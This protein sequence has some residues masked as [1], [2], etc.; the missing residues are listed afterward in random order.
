MFLNIFSNSI[1]IRLSKTFRKWTGFPT[2]PEH[3][4]ISSRALPMPSSLLS[5]LVSAIAIAIITALA[6]GCSP[7]PNPQPDNQKT[8]SSSSSLGGNQQNSSTTSSKQQLT[9]PASI[10][11]LVEPIAMAFT[12]DK[13]ILITERGGNIRVVKNGRLRS[14][15]YADIIV[16]KLTGYSETGLLGIAID[17]NFK[18]KPYVYVYRTYSKN[19]KLFN[20]VIRLTDV[21]GSGREP[22]IILDNIPGGRI[23]NGGIIAF[24]PD[25]NLYISTGE[26][27]N[28]QLAQDLNSLGGKVLRIKPDGTIPA[29]NPFQNSPVFS[30]GHRNIFGMAF[31]P[32]TGALFIT[33]NG[34]DSDDEINEIVPGGNYGWPL[35]LGTSKNSRFINP[36]KT[37]PTVIA[38]TQ[39]IFYTGSILR[40]Y[41]NWFLFGAY[42]SKN[43]HALDITESTVSATAKVEQDKTIYHFG[44]R[45][46][47]LSQS[48]DGAIYVVGGNS[49]K[50]L[51][52]LQ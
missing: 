44:D 13:R 29:D 37:Y 42:N 20:K 40:N 5:L 35:A 1:V 46:V 2:S 50:K 26:T 51:T 41:K 11:D 32:G 38:P 23:H 52:A 7:Q 25:G 36:V 45:V 8:T 19:G 39:A 6:A 28:K 12:P 10:T 17:P 4:I 9:Y 43:I 22:K 30:Y 24:G 33:E 31:S 18:T 16:P 21:K 48:P 3:L 14:D 15:P 27:G 47:G 34:P 49:I